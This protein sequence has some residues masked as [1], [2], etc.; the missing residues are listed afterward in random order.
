MYFRLLQFMYLQLQSKSLAHFKL[1]IHASQALVS[2]SDRE[3]ARMQVD[4]GLR[5]FQSHFCKNT[6]ES[7]VLKS[8]IV[9]GQF[10][11]RPVP[12]SMWAAGLWLEEDDPPS[13]T[14]VSERIPDH[15]QP[16]KGLLLGDR[17][18]IAATASELGSSRQRLPPKLGKCLLSWALNF[19]ET[20][21]TTKLIGN[22]HRLQ[23]NPHLMQKLPRNQDHILS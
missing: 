22:Q 1:V 10:Q 16:P 21:S 3:N 18:V 7:E 9:F 13:T 6:S 23:E 4:L 12:K 14:S 8:F 5:L 15:S 19:R 17:L 20:L 2:R 11:A